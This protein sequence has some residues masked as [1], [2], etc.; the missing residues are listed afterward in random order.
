MIGGGI[1]AAKAGTAYACQHAVQLDDKT[2]MSLGLRRLAF[3]ALDGGL[4][5]L[6]MVLRVCN[7]LHIRLALSSDMSSEKLLGSCHQS[8]AAQALSCVF[9]V[10]YFD[11]LEISN[12]GCVWHACWNP[13][14]SRSS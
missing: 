14:G 5:D 12:V 13:C 10:S 11:S 6:S 4:S 9:D 2:G 7:R 3:W 8:H 1:C